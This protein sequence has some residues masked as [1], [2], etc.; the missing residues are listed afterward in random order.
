VSVGYEDFGYRPT[1]KVWLG[2]KILTDI[3]PSILEDGSWI[4]R[5]IAVAMTWYK[6]LCRTTEG[7]PKVPEDPRKWG[8]KELDAIAEAL[9]S[10]AKSLLE[11]AL[12][13]PPIPEAR[14]RRIT[15]NL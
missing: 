5:R 9:V 6:F 1:A 2:I 4:G 3:V 14:A 13:V 10:Y 7:C 12:R 11:D 15:S 8:S